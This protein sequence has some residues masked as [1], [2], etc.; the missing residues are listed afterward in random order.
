MYLD[1][2]AS[3]ASTES[4]SK[5]C[6]YLPSRRGQKRRAAA[7][8]EPTAVRR[9]FES[10]I[11]NLAVVDFPTPGRLASVTNP[12]CESGPL[13]REPASH[14][15]VI[16]EA[17]LTNTLHVSEIVTDQPTA[18][19]PLSQIAPRRYHD[20]GLVNLFYAN[21]HSAH[22]ILLPRSMYNE[23]TYPESLQLAVQFVDSHFSTTTSSDSLC[24]ATAEALRDD[25]Q[26]GFH[27]VQARL[28]FAIAL[29]SRNEIRESVSVLADA[30]SLTINLGMNR[31]DFSQR[32]GNTEIEAESIR[33]TWWELYVIDGIMAALQRN[34][35]FRCHTIKTE[36]LLPCDENLCH[37]NT[38]PEPFSMAQFDARVYGDEDRPFSSFTYRI[39]ANHM[40]AIDNAITAWFHHLP[41][42]QGQID[43]LDL[44]DSDDEKLFQAHMLINYA[45][46]Y[47]HFPRSDL[48]PALPA[49][50]DVIRERFL[51]P[52]S[53]QHMHA[54]KTISASKCLGSLA[55][56]PSTVRKHSPFFICCVVFIIIVQLSA[57][58]ANRPGSYDKHWDQIKLIMGVLKTLGRM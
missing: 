42:G 33:R 6:N 12:H 19:P 43:M 17:S 28:L 26:Q 3:L 27:L 48:A 44:N 35:T 55:S 2:P 29:H 47:L 4:A 21:F 5:E 58:A 1:R 46:M 31:K 32:H 7:S 40:K 18:A 16:Q 24:T 36:V 13:E 15:G 56:C 52:T 45:T 54:L 25:D 30:V 10:T 53:S 23:E 9:A 51:L 34:P 49:A 38:I 8:I 39:D 20:E 14:L 22:P 11:E 41:D 37:N 57:C 50:R